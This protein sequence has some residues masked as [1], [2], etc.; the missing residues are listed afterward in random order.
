M[1]KVTNH[2]TFHPICMHT[3]PASL[4]APIP[5]QTSPLKLTD[6]S[7]E[8]EKLAKKLKTKEMERLM[9]LVNLAQ[10]YDPRIVADKERIKQVRSAGQ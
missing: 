4:V 3:Y 7:Q 6:F 9:A 10:K 1:Q 2:S 8:N 5:C